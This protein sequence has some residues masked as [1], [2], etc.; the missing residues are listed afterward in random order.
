MGTMRLFIAALLTLAITNISEGQLF[1]RLRRQRA[2]TYSLPTAGTDQ[3]RCEQEARA[4]AQRGYRGHLGGTIGLFEG[5]GWSSSGLPSTCVPRRR[6]RLTGDATA[7]SRFGS[8]RVRSW[9]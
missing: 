8:F 1:R 2:Y 7:R 6:M 4:M 9:R 5:V 3:Q